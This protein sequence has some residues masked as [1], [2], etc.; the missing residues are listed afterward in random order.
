MNINDVNILPTTL[1]IEEKKR[2][3]SKCVGDVN[4]VVVFGTDEENI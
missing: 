4:S 3:N 1:Q 2:K